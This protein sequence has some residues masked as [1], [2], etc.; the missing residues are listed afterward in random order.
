M[1]LCMNSA[2][3]HAPGV[4]S[5]KMDFETNVLLKNILASFTAFFGRRKITRTEAIEL[6]C[7]GSELKG[8]GEYSAKQHFNLDGVSTVMHCHYK[9]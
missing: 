9:V 4:L 7:Y 6:L 5:C 2:R 3:I 8:S 1:L